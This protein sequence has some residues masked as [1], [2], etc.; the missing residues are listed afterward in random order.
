MEII[1]SLILRVLYTAV[2]GPEQGGMI[3]ESRGGDQG[4]AEDQK[5]RTETDPRY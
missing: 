5:R 2:Q 3:R 1:Q 4:G